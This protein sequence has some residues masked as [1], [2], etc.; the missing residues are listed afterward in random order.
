MV[1]DAAGLIGQPLAFEPARAGVGDRDP[2]AGFRRPE[3]PPGQV[4][5][6]PVQAQPMTGHDNQKDQPRRQGDPA[7]RAPHAQQG[8][9][10]NTRRSSS[11]CGP[12]RSV[13]QSPPQTISVP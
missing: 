2:G 5:R 6:V 4:E 7:C 1:F 9:Q 11:K 13:G 10:G 3:T 12:S 8:P